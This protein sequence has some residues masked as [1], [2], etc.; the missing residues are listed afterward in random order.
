MFLYVVSFVIVVFG[1]FIFNLKPVP[2]AQPRIQ[3]QELFKLRSRLRRRRQASA[4]PTTQQHKDKI[5]AEGS[6]LISKDNYSSR[7]DPVAA[8]RHRSPEGSSSSGATPVRGG[9]SIVISSSQST[10]GSY[11]RDGSDILRKVGSR[12]SVKPPLTHESSHHDIHP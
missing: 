11:S 5:T 2:I 7:S 8:G 12:D 4:T 6:V 1:V 3:L 10:Y 9:S